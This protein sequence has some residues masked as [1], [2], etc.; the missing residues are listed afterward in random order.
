[1]ISLNV[2]KSD[3][4]KVISLIFPYA[5]NNKLFHSYIE[6]LYFELNTRKNNESCEYLEFFLQVKPYNKV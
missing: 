6:E 4:Q 1:M 2:P 5:D 3:E